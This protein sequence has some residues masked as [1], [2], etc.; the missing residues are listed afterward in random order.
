MRVAL[1]SRAVLPLHGYGGL[2]R[3]VAALD[4]YLRLEGC[5]VTLYTAPP[6]SS[7]PAHGLDG[8][9][10]VPYRLLPWPRRSGFTVLDRNTNY[11]GWSVRAGRRVLSDRRP[12]V[13]Q[14]DGGAGFGYALFS[15]AG[16]PPLVLHPH[17]MEEFEAPPLKRALYQPLRSAVRFTARRAARVIAPDA[18]MKGDVQRHLGVREEKVAVVPNAIDLSDIDRAPPPIDLG[19]PESARVLLS[20]GRLEQNKGF[21]LLARALARVREDFFWVQVGSGPERA[22]LE[23]E[24]ERLGL[25]DR[26]L[27]TGKVA[28]ER[29]H[30]LYERCALFLHPTLNEGSSQVTLEAMAH[31]KPV[32]GSRV[33]GI[34]DKVADGEN[35]LLVPPGDVEA[36]AQAIANALSSPD[37]LRTWGAKSRAI[38]EARFSW[39]KRVKEL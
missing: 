39:S 13:V 23:S 35:G 8:T 6:E 30:A 10:F 17:G 29:L 38:V 22:R 1:L 37:R 33:G 18:S 27:L 25:S 28:D 14:A 5:E 20:V 21:S 31:A 34:P 3:H 7:A 15:R 26:A 4:K 19:I 12:D 16:S 24:I 9:V 36:L 2:E 11:L 32:V